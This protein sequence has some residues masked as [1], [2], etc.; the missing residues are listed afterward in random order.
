MLKNQPQFDGVADTCILPEVQLSVYIQLL[1]IQYGYTHPIV[2]GD[3]VSNRNQ[4][5]G[6][7]INKNGKFRLPDSPLS[8]GI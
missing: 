1:Q 7:L 8:V 2:S 4:K 3:R 6:V 5:N